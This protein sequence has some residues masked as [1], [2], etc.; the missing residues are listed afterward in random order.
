[1][2][3]NA[4][5]CNAFLALDRSNTPFA[6]TATSFLFPTPKNRLM[7]AFRSLSSYAK[8]IKCCADICKLPSQNMNV[9][10]RKEIAEVV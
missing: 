6:V 8:G 1:L 9:P 10:P 4:H 5:S 3:S 7:Q 2:S